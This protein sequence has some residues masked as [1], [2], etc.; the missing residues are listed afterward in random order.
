MTIYNEHVQTKTGFVFE[1]KNPTGFYEWEKVEIN[2]QNNHTYAWGSNDSF[3]F[4]VHPDR[5]TAVAKYHNLITANMVK[6]GCNS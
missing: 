4:E 1:R 5:E 6:V 2:F 3:E